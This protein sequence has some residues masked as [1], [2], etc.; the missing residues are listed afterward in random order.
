L[1]DFFYDSNPIQI[2]IEFKDPEYNNHID[3][4]VDSAYTTRPLFVENE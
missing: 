3:I 1:L 2:E 4:K